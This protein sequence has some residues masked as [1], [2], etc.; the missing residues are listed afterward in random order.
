MK[1]S[2]EKK[3]CKLQR[4]IYGLKQAPCLSKLD[5]IKLLRHIFFTK[6]QLSLEYTKKEIVFLILYID[7]ILLI[8]NGVWT[9]SYAKK[10]LSQQFDMMDFEEASYILGICIL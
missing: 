6:I 7:D 10:W 5:L 8:G 1:E 2:H 3:L 4:P 9:L